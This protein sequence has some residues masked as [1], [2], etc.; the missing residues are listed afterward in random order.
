L[1]KFTGRSLAKL[2]GRSLAKLTGRSLA[3][4]TDRLF[5]ARIVWVVEARFRFQLQLRQQRKL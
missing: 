5:L 4:L 3:K 1:V 2:T